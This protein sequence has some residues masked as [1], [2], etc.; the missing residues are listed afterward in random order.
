MPSL[1]QPKNVLAT[2]SKNFK[3]TLPTK[4]S[5]TRI[6]VPPFAIS[7]ASTLPTKLMFLQSRSNGYVS[8]TS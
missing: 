2:P 3:I 4:A 1:M 8:F 6:S 7:L 5:Q